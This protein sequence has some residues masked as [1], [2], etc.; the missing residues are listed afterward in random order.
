MRALLALVLAAL[1]PGAAAEYAG[2]ALDAC[3]AHGERALRADGA[4]VKAL[5]FDN[6]RHLVYAREARRLGSQPLGASLSGHGAIVRATGP[7]VEVAFLCLL[8]SEKRALWFDWLPRRDAPA[9]AQCRRGAHAGACLQLMLDLAERDL[10][11]K[12]ALRFQASLE[13]DAQAGNEAASS[14]YR[15]SAAAWR[16]YRDL[17]CARRGP[18]SSDAWLACRVDLTRWRYLDLQ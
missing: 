15:N 4:D 12:A 5:A 9:L 16:N 13:A 1:P 2:P 11:E 7:A 14:A 10:L 18:A 6:D 17:E 3:R 8:A